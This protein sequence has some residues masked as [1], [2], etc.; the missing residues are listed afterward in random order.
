MG[1]LLSLYNVLPYP[2]KVLA[3]SAIGFRLANTRYDKETDTLVEEALARESWTAEKW[4]SWQ[5]EI[6]SQMLHHA[7]K[8][9]PYYRDKWAARRRT[10]DRASIEY[11]ENWP[12]LQKQEL[13]SR[14][15]S[16]ISDHF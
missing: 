3:A 4:K 8:N 10:G 2:F 7:A 14:T 15:D 12:V 5:D 9:V 6:L 13:R 16:F 11:L 1:D